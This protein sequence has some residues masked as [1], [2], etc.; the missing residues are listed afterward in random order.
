MANLNFQ[1][2]PRSIANAALA[3]RTT[4]GFGGSSLA[5]HVTPTS[6]MFQTGKHLSPKAFDGA[7]IHICCLRLRQLLSRNGELRTGAAAAATTAAAAPTVAEPECPAVGRRTRHLERQPQRQPLRPA[8][9]CGAASH[10]RIGQWPHGKQRGIT[11]KSN[12]SNSVLSKILKVKHI[13]ISIS[14][15]CGFST[16]ILR[17][18]SENRIA[19]RSDLYKGN[20]FDTTEYTL[21][22]EVTNAFTLHKKYTL[23]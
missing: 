23:Y 11:T 7:P 8:S 14:I 5:G 10:A 17:I 22:S 15:D 19:D 18:A 3:G 21:I 20:I 2:P 1:Q 9:V 16:S 12:S 6:G 13:T 4:G